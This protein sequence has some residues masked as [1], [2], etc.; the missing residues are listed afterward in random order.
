MIEKISHYALTNLGT[1]YDEE[2]MS[3]LQL[4]GKNAKKTNE[5]VDKVNEFEGRVDSMQDYLNEGGVVVSVNDRLDK[6]VSTGELASYINDKAMA[7]KADRLLVEA[8]AS[9]SPAGV[10]STVEELTASTANKNR[11]YL[12]STYWY[13]WN[14]TAWTRGGQYLTGSV[15]EHTLTGDHIALNEITMASK[16]QF[17]RT[18]KKLTFYV[19]FYYDAD[20]RA[21]NH[22][23]GVGPTE[24]VVVDLSNLSETSLYW[25]C[26]DT[27]DN[28]IVV[29]ASNGS[30]NENYK[31]L[32]RYFNGEFYG[33][34]EKAITYVSS[35]TNPQG[36]TEVLSELS[37]NAKTIKFLGDSIT[38][39]VGATGYGITTTALGTNPAKYMPNQDSTCWA[40]K[41]GKKMVETL[42]REKILAPI[43][44]LFTAVGTNT[45][46]FNNS[47][48]SGIQT[49][50]YN[51]AQMIVNG[52]DFTLWFT[53][54]LDCGI[55]RVYIDDEVYGTYD[56]YNA[57]ALYAQPITIS[58]Q[59]DKEHIVSIE[60]YDVNASLTATNPC[61]RFEGVSY[62]RAFTYTNYGV[63]GWDALTVSN[64]IGALTNEKDNLVVVAL[65]TNDR[66]K[67]S[68]GVYYQAMKN[69]LTQI[70]NQGSKALVILPIPHPTEAEGNYN[71]S[72]ADVVRTGK[73]L[74]ETMHVPYVDLNG[75]I[76]NYVRTTG[77]SLESLYSDGLHPNDA[78]YDAITQ[79][80]SNYLNV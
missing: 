37:N 71:F 80:L 7:N 69:I 21:Y 46:A 54:Y 66:L 4:C 11:I 56:T 67:A 45:K 15:A 55:I 27:S 52:T 76:L 9:G 44:P 53:H 57:T 16:M 50:F 65:G 73:E 74:C 43:E 3:V 79:I 51:K 31:V 18:T 35:D 17:D 10:F 26:L 14:G 28:S 2:A 13:Y 32:L 72:I 77:L 42:T 59:L 41:L 58:N 22:G 62:N 60:L 70:I 1:M 24:E 23:V 20:D 39:G 33:V 8:L 25:I 19:P 47:A 5:L 48:K 68:E 75:D 61:I 36:W 29:T 38:A 40:N 34:N 78:G 63:S 6:M 12:V 30:W 49:R 64:N